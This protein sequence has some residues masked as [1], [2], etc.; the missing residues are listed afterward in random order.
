ML[1][2]RFHFSSILLFTANAGLCIQH[3]Y[4]I[5]TLN[6][7]CAV[8]ENTPVIIYQLVLGRSGARSLSH[9]KC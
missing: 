5:I 8:L 6:V 7:S 4:E 2:H 3:N 1:H 9:L